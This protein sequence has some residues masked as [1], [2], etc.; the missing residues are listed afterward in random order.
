M[1]QEL[2]VE[3][4]GISKYFPVKKGLFNSKSNPVRAVDGVDLHINRGETM[5]LVGES[6]SGKTT[7]GRMLLGLT[8]LSKGSVHFK[9]RN[10]AEVGRRDMLKLRQQMQIVFQDPYGSLNPK[11]TV[12]EAIGEPLA[13]HKSVKKASEKAKVIEILE[14]VGLSPDHYNRYP[15][16]FSGGQRQ[17]IGIAR[18]LILNPEFVVCDEPVSALDVS[19]QS[20]IL[21]LLVDLQS[22][23]NLTYLFISHDLRVVR[24][25][26]TQVAVMYLGKIVEV[27]PS[28]E[29]FEN[30]RHPYTQALISAIPK[31]KYGEKTQRLILEGDIPNPSNPPEG[32]H[33]HPRCRQAIPLCKENQPGMIEVRANHYVRCYCAQ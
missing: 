22:K 15:H 4:K 23:Y 16:E 3:A 10:L 20:Q 1:R 5:G 21:N 11:I 18:A 32:C 30:P 33:L 12:G 2:L 28:E 27:A 7:T 24:Y 6:G 31:P 26:C 14:T 17:R 8:S 29:L 9:S 25:I 13:I 19:I